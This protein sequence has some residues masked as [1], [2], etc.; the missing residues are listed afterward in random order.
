[1]FSKK[2]LEAQKEEVAFSPLSNVCDMGHGSQET[3]LKQI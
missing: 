3:A 2:V 1:M